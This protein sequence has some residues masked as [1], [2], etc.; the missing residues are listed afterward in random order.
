MELQ[1]NV[2]TNDFYSVITC[3]GESCTCPFNLLYTSSMMVINHNSTAS[4]YLSTIS[5]TALI[6]RCFRMS[7][8]TTT[9]QNISNR[10]IL[11]TSEPNPFMGK[12]YSRLP[13]QIHQKFFL[14][15]DGTTTRFPTNLF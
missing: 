1:M 10:S 2:T 9:Y 14:T 15:P 11:L 3:K 12:K 8:S 13:L 6:S 5:F 7:M 4:L